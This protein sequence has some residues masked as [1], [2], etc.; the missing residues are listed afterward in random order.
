MTPVV[1]FAELDGLALVPC[2]IIG[3]GAAVF[4]GWILAALLSE[5]VP[6]DAEWRYDVSRINA[7]RRSDAT[8]RLLQPIV[9]LL[10]KLNRAAFGAS[11]P[12]MQRELLAAGYSRYWLPE[13]FLARAQIHAVLLMPGIIYACVEMM[14]GP[15]VVM[16]ILFTGIVAW[17]LRRRLAQAAARRVLVIKRRLPFLLDLL[18]L[19]MEAGSSFLNAL[20]EAVREFGDHPIGVEFGRVLADLNMGKVRTEAFENLRKR[21]GDEEIASIVGSI[22]QSEQLGTPLATIFRT[23]ADVLRVKRSQRAE[24]IA[25]EAGVRMLLPAVLVMA[26]AVI[27]ILGPFL[28]NFVYSGFGL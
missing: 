16:G 14:G 28:L 12:E 19:L 3:L 20:H 24:T 4:V 23:Q 10:A 27:I 17:L 8:Y 22:I 18:T 13:E 6:Q 21:L 15:G 11:L 9:T 1:L 25:N 7:L 2:A 26:A 5:D